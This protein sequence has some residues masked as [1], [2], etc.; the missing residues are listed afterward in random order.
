[1]T[2]NNDKKKRNV[3]IVGGGLAGL[4]VAYQLLEKAN[5]AEADDE[6]EKEIICITILDKTHVGMGGASSVAGGLLHPFSPRGKLVHL[7]LEGLQSTLHLLSIASSYE[8]TCILKPS[9]YRLALTDNHVSQLQQTAELYPEH[10]TWLGKET[11]TRKCCPFVEE[12]GEE[13]I[14]WKGG[15]ELTSG[16]VI[17][18]PT[19]LKGLWKAC[20]DLS[21]PLSTKKNDIIDTETTARWIVMENKEKEKEWMDKL[22][23]FD[24]VILAAGAGLWMS[25]LEKE[26]KDQVRGMLANIGESE[27]QSNKNVITGKWPIQLVRGQSVELSLSTQQ[28]G[29]YNSEALLCG[30]YTSPLPSSQR[31]KEDCQNDNFVLVGA[32]HEYDVSKALSKEEVINDLRSRSYDVFPWIWDEGTVHNITEGWRVQSNRGLF[33]RVPIVGRLPSTSSLGQES[34]ERNGTMLN[35]KD[36]WIFTGLSS[37]GLIHHGVYGGILADAILNRCEENMV[38]EYDGIQ[39]WRKALEKE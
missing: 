4:S 15:L 9:L 21:S 32:T 29:E 35:H 18:V 19:Y 12:E 6:S 36:A 5:D 14:K 25:S 1:M 24:T 38:S 8:S 26:H 20:L 30:K 17:H 7:G 22:Q 37:R 16:K 39:W 28:R 33:G 11:L 3:A 27:M 10:C 2:S 31:R 34:E 23:E 13:K